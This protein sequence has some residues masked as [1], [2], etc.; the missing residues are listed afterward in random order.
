MEAREIRWMENVLQ[1]QSLYLFCQHFSDL[2]ESPYLQSCY[3]AYSDHLFAS[4]F[5]YFCLHPSNIVACVSR[6][7]AVKTEQ[8]SFQRAIGTTVWTCSLWV[9]FSLVGIMCYSLHSRTFSL[10]LPVS[11]GLT[12]RDIM[13]LVK[14]YLRSLAKEWSDEKVVVLSKGKRQNCPSSPFSEPAPL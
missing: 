5:W 1:L 12:R 6:A 9:F 2:F 11:A 13:M 3:S 14:V 7:V 4:G 8:C 10:L